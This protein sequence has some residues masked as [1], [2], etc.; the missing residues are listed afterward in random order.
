MRN[1]MINLIVLHSGT[2]MA[3]QNQT[4]NAEAASTSSNRSVNNYILQSRDGCMFCKPYYWQYDHSGE[5]DTVNES[6]PS[7]VVCP[8]L[9][10]FRQLL[11]YWTEYYLRRG[12]DRLSL[13]FSSHIAFSSWRDIVG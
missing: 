2:P 10:N 13:E 5:S 4:E 7:N 8:V 3:E 9:I 1:E 11:W 12:R 6:D